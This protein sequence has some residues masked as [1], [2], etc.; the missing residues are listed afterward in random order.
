VQPVLE[1]PGPSSNRV[2]PSPPRAPETPATP[3]RTA[4]RPGPALVSCQFNSRLQRLVDFQLPDLQ[5]TPVRFQD[6]DA[7]LVLL[8]FWGTWCGPCVNSIPHLVD[9]QKRF[10]PRQL[11]VIGIAYEQGPT[12]GR[13]TVV[14]AS[15]RKMGINYTV[16]LGESDGQPCPL[17]EALHVQAYPTLVLLDRQGRILWRDQGASSLT[18]ARLDRVIASN[19]GS[20]SRIVRR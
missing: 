19:T 7:D 3:V 17:Q 9:L 15:S 6:L 11:R 5:G 20:P 18:L 4:D 14:A 2:A 8:D 10:G 12:Q 13:A 1:L 16:L